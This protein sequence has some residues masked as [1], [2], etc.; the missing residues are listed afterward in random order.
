MKSKTTNIH[1]LDGFTKGLRDFST[2]LS[3]SLAQKTR[4]TMVDEARYAIQEFYKDYTPVRYRRHYK[5]FLTKSFYG[6]YKNPH[7]QVIRGG[8]E[9]SYEKMDD[10]YRGDLDLIFSTVYSGQ[11]G[12][13]QMI[14]SR[15][16][17]PRIPD[18]KPSPMHIIMDK[19]DWIINNI[20]SFS[21]DVLA[22]FNYNCEYFSF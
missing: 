10:I 6:F 9:L 12:N 18:M 20:D 4:E 5:N 16:N 3:K 7:G 11:H 8:V 15:K 19:R 22:L 21:D 17:V 1:I 14:P 2:A 13:I